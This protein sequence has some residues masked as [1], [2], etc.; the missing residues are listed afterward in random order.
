[1]SEDPEKHIAPMFHTLVGDVQ[2][3]AVTELDEEYERDRQW[4][5][6]QRQRLGTLNSSDLMRQIAG[7]LTQEEAHAKLNAELDK[8]NREAKEAATAQEESTN[9]QFPT[10]H[11][12]APPITVGE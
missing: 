6:E 10:D 3:N 2:A 7:E 5:E 4:R 9:E 8:I 11:F 1:M 12:P